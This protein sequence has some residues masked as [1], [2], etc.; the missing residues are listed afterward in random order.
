[1]ALRHSCWSLNLALIFNTPSQDTYMKRVKR[2]DWKT[3]PLPERF[4]TSPLD[5]NY[6]AEESDL[7]M[8]GFLPLEMEDNKW[9]LFFEN[10][11]LFCH[12]SW[13][14]FCMY[15]VHFVRDRES[16][17]AT[18]AEVN[19]DPDQNSN[20]DDAEDVEHIYSVIQG[21]LLTR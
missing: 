20:T 21:F 16:L 14:G 1:M 6:S 5:R 17:R 8:A 12:R 4:S 19:R 7:I 3:L 9:F 15:Q 10:N 13:T 11:T 18:H 2:S